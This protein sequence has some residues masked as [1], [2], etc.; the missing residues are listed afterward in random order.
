MF[1]VHVTAYLL[2]FWLCS[3]LVSCAIPKSFHSCSRRT[4]GVVFFSS[5]KMALWPFLMENVIEKRWRKYCFRTLAY[6]STFQYRF[7]WIRKQIY[8]TTLKEITDKIAKN[9]F[10]LCTKYKWM[11]RSMEIFAISFF[12]GRFSVWLWF[13]F[14]WIVWTYGTI[15]QQ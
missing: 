9:Y 15:H 6:Q 3:A 12:V 2:Y 7:K 5:L 13:S 11:H 1:I 14:E 4:C 10:A 8:G